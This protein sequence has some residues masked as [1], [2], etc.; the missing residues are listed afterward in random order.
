MPHNNDMQELHEKYVAVIGLEVHAQLQTRSKIYN[1]D[2][3]TFGN[4]PNTNVGV[5]TLAHP[6]T[7]PQLNKLAVEHAIRMGLACKYF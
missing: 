6:G 5:V 2:A 7:L 3:T 4:S 1:S